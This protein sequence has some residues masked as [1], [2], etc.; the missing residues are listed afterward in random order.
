MGARLIRAAFAGL[1]WLATAGHPAFGQS[2]VMSLNVCTDQLVMLLAEPGQILSVSALAGEPGLSFLH[3][4]AAGLPRNGGL[5]EEVLLAKPGLVVTG[6][7][8]LHNT[9]GLLRGLG[10]RIEEFEFAQTLDTIPGEIRRMGALLGQ[11]EAAAREAS[12][13]EASV[14]EARRAAC[15]ANP[16]AI[17]WEQNGI[18]L[19]AGT[20]ADS[21]MQAA[22]FRNLAAELGFEGMTPFPLELLVSHKPDIILLP[23]D[24]A[25]APSLADLSAR[26]PALAAANA[27]RRGSVVP[28][29]SWSCGGPGVIGA[30]KAL[31][32]LRAEMRPCPQGA[33]Q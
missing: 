21:V 2:R 9:T 22:G 32:S 10:Y 28:P 6:T 27:V 1:A 30:V 16:T 5:A 26:H 31:A 29:G 19:G 8:S 7:F 13:F 12:A 15:G 4:K 14:A 24:K 20:L 11:T 25:G 18:A 3:E 33:V 17:A 23:D